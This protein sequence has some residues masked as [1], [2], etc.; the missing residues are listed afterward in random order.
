MFLHIGENRM[1]PQSEIIMIGDLEKIID[2]RISKEFM[3]YRNPKNIENL[4]PEKIKSFIL[5]DDG[6]YYSIIASSTLK[7]RINKGF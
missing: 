5:T 7:K 6:I 1:I 3:E 2:S 4:D